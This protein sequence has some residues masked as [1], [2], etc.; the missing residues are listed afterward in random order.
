MNLFCIPSALQIDMDDMGWFCGKDERKTGGPSRT[1]V[2]RRHCALDYL[3]VNELGRRLNMRINCAFV[4]GEWDSDNALRAIP[5]L[6]QYGDA[7]DNAAYYNEAEMR[8][9]VDAINQS[10]YTN[11]CVH[12][13]MHGY[14]MNGVDW[15]DS[16]DFYYRI[17]NKLYMIPEEEVRARLDAF[18]GLLAAQGV[19]KK[20][21]TFIPP[22]FAY[23]FNELS[24][25]LRAYGIEYVG[26]IFKTAEYEGSAPVEPIDIEECGMV[27]YDRHHNPIPW[28][29]FGGD[30]DSLPPLCGLVGVHWPNFLHEDPERNLESVESAERYFRRAAEEFGTI[31]SRGVEFYASQALYCRYAVAEENDGVFIVDLSGLPKSYAVRDRFYVSARKAIADCEGCAVSVYEKIGDFMT[32]EVIPLSKKM[33]IRAKI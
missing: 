10:P 6:S 30:W 4:V 8:A 13:L 26:T 5:H 14:Y 12:G 23:R 18:F 3:A 1:G 31:L 15:H 32:Y 9:C 27:T 20:T 33:T 17:K 24:P 22:S 11:L 25:I 16:S 7:W 19:K 2:N 21:N 28:D 29:S